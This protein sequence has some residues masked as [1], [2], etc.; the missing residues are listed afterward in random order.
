MTV[1]WCDCTGEGVKSVISLLR[2]WLAL[3]AGP[4]VA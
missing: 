1:D 3:R 4:K 2:G